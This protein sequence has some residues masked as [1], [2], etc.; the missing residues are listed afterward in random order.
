MRDSI[1]SFLNEN[2][3]I[4][5]NRLVINRDKNDK[6]YKQK[7]PVRYLE[8]NQTELYNEFPHADKISKD[9]FIKYMKMSNE[10]K[11][12]FRWTDLCDYCEKGKKI[13][14]DLVRALTDLKYEWQTNFDL[15]HIRK[16]LI[17]KRNEFG[18]KCAAAAAESGDNRQELDLYNELKNVNTTIENVDCYDAIEF[19]KNVA[20]CQ[21]IAYNNH[22]KNVDVLRGKIMI[23][24]DFKQKIVIGMGGPRQVNSEYYEQQ[25]RSCLGN[26]YECIKNKN[27]MNFIKNNNSL[28]LFW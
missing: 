23:E 26:L 3:N 9:T 4:G 18:G 11:K 24:V 12:P 1:R 21:R 19:H 14:S 16:F 6:R 17:D 5:A 27:K 8:K 2:S 25:Q 7:I 20:R 15:E 10:F 22:R 28:Y 13:K